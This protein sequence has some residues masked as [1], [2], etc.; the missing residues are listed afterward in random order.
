MDTEKNNYY[1]DYFEKAFIVISRKMA[2]IDFEKSPSPEK[3]GIETLAVI[4]GITGMNKGRVLIEMNLETANTIAC[5]INSEPEISIMDIYVTL[6]EFSNIVSGRAITY[7]NN[8][9]PKSSL[10]LTPPAIFSGSNLEISTP[11]LKF[12]NT[13]LKS[14]PGIVHIN[15]GFES[16]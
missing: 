2:D 4:L 12:E 11:K 15:I 13:Y 8:E 10:R 16:R 7:I 1:L 6:A 9:Y 3:L 14:E 5:I